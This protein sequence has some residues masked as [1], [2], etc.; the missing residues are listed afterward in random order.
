MDRLQYLC[1]LCEFGFTSLGIPLR[2]TAGRVSIWSWVDCNTFSATACI[3][4]SVRLI[5]IS[6]VFKSA[7][8]D[9]SPSSAK[10]LAAAARRYCKS[11]WTLKKN[12]ILNALKIN[13]GN[14]FAMITFAMILPMLSPFSSRSR[15]RDITN[16]YTFSFVPVTIETN[17]E[18]KDGGDYLASSFAQQGSVYELSGNRGKVGT[19]FC[20][21]C[22]R[23]GACVP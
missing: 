21:D 11:S 2:A 8:L 12:I 13:Y 15:A 3:P 4:C 19:P 5:T 22:K 9:L 10:P 6:R 20:P 1:F 14:T 17:F 7:D 18:P 16:V 23:Y